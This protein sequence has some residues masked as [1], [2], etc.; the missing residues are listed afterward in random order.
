MLTPLQLALDLGGVFVFGLSGALVGV[1]NRLDVLGILMLAGLTGLGGGV[2]RDVLIGSVPPANLADWRYLLVP[3]LAGLVAFR[4]HPRLSR[5]ERYINW[6]DALGLGLFCVTGAAKA[7]QFGLNPVAAA[8]LGMLTAVGGGI[9]RD[10]V[11]GRT[12]LVI[13]ND[14]VYALAALAGAC[15]VV[16]AWETGWYAPW[17]AVAG[18]GVCIAL[19]LLAIRY[20]WRVPR[21]QSPD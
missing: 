3:A 16:V 8:L 4:F 14:E 17:V 7:L 21:A 19:R 6:F 9:L 20:S 1:R 10:V 15:V 11:A 2:V 5:I 13:R 12:P 18:A